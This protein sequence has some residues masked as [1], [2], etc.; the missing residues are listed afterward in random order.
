MRILVTG[1]AGRLG[2]ATLAQLRASSHSV[3]AVDRHPATSDGVTVSALDLL[4]EMATRA[5]FDA[6]RPEVVIHLANHPNASVAPAAQLY[7]ENTAMTWHVFAAAIDAGARRILYASSVQAIS[8]GPGRENVY[9]SDLPVF[10]LPVD[11]TEPTQVGNAYGLSKVAGEQALALL[12]AQ[13]P[14]VAG[15]ALRFPM[16]V[17]DPAG[18]PPWL[19]DV[20]WTRPHPEFHAYLPIGAAADL[21]VTLSGSTLSG[22][23]VFTPACPLPAHAPRLSALLDGPYRGMTVRRPPD[24]FTQPFDPERLAALTG[25]RPP[26]PEVP[27]PKA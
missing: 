5:A 2:R 22:Y 17:T 12:V 11:G 3:C 8:G 18:Y 9:L 27:P 13:H 25:W 23:H 4:D 19:S 24:S 7:R 16:L 6:F 1:A 21:L 26:A 20:A 15:V 14:D 10:P